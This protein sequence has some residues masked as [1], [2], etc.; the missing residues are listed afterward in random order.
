M[1][2]LSTAD[3][4][5]GLN[6]NLS[7]NYNF[8]TCNLPQA[9]PL[10]PKSAYNVSTY[11]LYSFTPPSGSAATNSNILSKFSQFGAIQPSSRILRQKLNGLGSAQARHMIDTELFASWQMRAARRHKASISVNWSVSHDDCAT[12]DCRCSNT[13]THTS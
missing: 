8:Y 12:H 11:W 6:G 7:N 10:P 4:S 3:S 1:P 2:K 9:S 5:N 13:N